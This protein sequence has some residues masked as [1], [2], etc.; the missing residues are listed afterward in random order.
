MDEADSYVADWFARDPGSEIGQRFCPPAQ[1]RVFALW[2]ALLEQLEQARFDIAEPGVA[3][4]KLGWW[5]EDLQH[6][7]AGH[8]RHPLGHAFFAEA[9]AGAVAPARWVALARASAAHGD[10]GVVPSRVEDLLDV[11]REWAEAVAAIESDLFDS[12][13][14]GVAVA[15][16]QRL[17][18]WPAFGDSTPG[19][20]W[21]LQLMARHQARVED[22]ASR[23]PAPPARAVA[24]DLAAELLAILAS[25]PGG[26]VFRARR[27]ARDAWR[28]RQWAAGR[29]D[30][31]FP[32][33]M[34]Q[35]WQ[36]WNAARAATAVRRA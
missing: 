6:G 17:R 9:A 18:Q 34:Q 19:W 27:S 30:A 23:P 5:L 2:G 14:P 25:V 3:Q 26:P 8:A 33:R 29:W 7:A 20:R 22:F 11:D 31:R 15:I 4:A 24:R 12:P 21:P 1:R 32:G 10:S 36:S 28:L 35:L 16:S 13:S